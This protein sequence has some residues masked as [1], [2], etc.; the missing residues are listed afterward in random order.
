M[1]R[2]GIAIFALL[3]FAAAMLASG[4][5]LGGEFHTRNLLFCSQ[6][7]TI[8]GSQQHTYN[9]TGAGVVFPPV[10]NDGTV[11]EYLLKN[12]INELCL[13]CHDG[14]AAHDVLEAG[15]FVRQAGGL[16]RTD[17]SGDYTPLTG[18]TLGT[19]A[20]PP[21]NDGSYDPGGHGLTC[22]NCHHQHGYAGFGFPDGEKGA[23]VNLRDIDARG[24]TYARGTNDTAFDVFRRNGSHSEDSIDFNEP[25]QTASVYA[26]WCGN[27]HTDFH[28]AANSDNIGGVGGT[29]TSAFVR[30]PVAGVNIGAVGGGHSNKDVFAT[31]DTGVP[32]TKTHY[33]QV[34]T[35][36]ENWEPTAE[37]DV[38]DH[39]PSCMSCH[40]A[41]G[42]KNVFGLIYR[43][44][45]ET[46]G[47]TEEGP[48][49][50][51]EHLCGQCHVQAI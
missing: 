42:N 14:T 37:T 9:K 27:C 30:H 31:A 2:N 40:K 12:E 45:T 32:G 10:A 25:D 23:Y 46:G 29:G 34:M 38:T 16:N 50:R 21:G 51:L 11:H 44:P 22:I 5:A 33:V 28:G 48:G 20:M 13:T 6:C 15:S 24:P 17:S 3:V 8:H 41:H 4:T 1:R 19:S 36:T 7:H 18:H 35:A 43:D 49:S 39:T 26:A 47:I